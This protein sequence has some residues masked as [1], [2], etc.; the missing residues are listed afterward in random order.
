MSARPSRVRLITAFAA[1]VTAWEALVHGSLLLNRSTP[2]L[3]GVRLASKV[4]L[5]QTIVP[6]LASVALARYAF[7]R[8]RPPLVF[9]IAARRV[10]RD[11]DIPVSRILVRAER[12]YADLAP[13][14]GMAVT[15]SG[16]VNL[17]MAAYMLALYRAMRDE[18]VSEER[19]TALLSHGLFRV[20]RQVWRAPDAIV[21]RLTRDHVRRARIRE[22]IARR[23]YFRSPDWEMHEVSYPGRHAV[24]ITRCVMRDFMVSEGATELCAEV[25]CAQDILMAEARGD[26]LIRTGTLARGADRCD[27]RFG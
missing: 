9:R 8:V 5:L 25:V 15:A 16:R 20:M 27:F 1:G 3:F 2:T 11:A 7:A 24:D 23:L 22:R 14:L 18:H 6:A 21:G 19:A 26:R 17:R 4:N 13:K 10:F 12:H